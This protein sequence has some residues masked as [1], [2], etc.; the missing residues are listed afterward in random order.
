MNTPV[1]VRFAPSPTGYL[2]VGGVR[3]LLFNWLFAQKMGGKLILR[4]EDTDQARSTRQSEDMVIEDIVQLGLTGHEGPIDGG[5]HA[6]YRQS[7]RMDIYG[8]HAQQLLDQGK[9]YY[10]FCSPDVIAAKREVALKLGRIPHYD[11]TCA[12]QS[13]HDAEA[14]LAKGE[15]AGLRFRAPEGAVRLEDAVR[16]AIEFGAGSVGDFMIT[17]SPT[18]EERKRGGLNAQVGMPVYNFC[19]VIDDHLMG[20]TH[21]IRGED[22]LSNTAR[23]LMVYDGLGWTKPVFAHIAMVLGSDRQKLSKRNGD[24]SARDYLN[25]GYLPEA[26]L[27]F[28][29]LLGW[30]PPQGTKPVSGHP[31]VLNRDELIAGFGLEG[32]Q[33]APAVFDLQKLAWMNGFYIKQ[34]SRDERY[35]RSEPFLDE[36]LKKRWSVEELTEW[37][38]LFQGEATVLTDWNRLLTP[39]VHVGE[40]L[41]PELMAELKSALAAAL[42]GQDAQTLRKAL[43][44]ELAQANTASLKELPQRIAKATGL[45]GKALYMPMRL[46]LTGQAHGPELGRV[47]AVLGAQALN[48]RWA[49]TEPAW[50]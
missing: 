42:A 4:I 29:A 11:G 50:P 2:H 14:R 30:W 6:P 48:K 18:E 37:L 41:G 10:C 33:K 1:R 5:P 34:L 38:D 9:A 15:R 46:A 39:Y 12:R 45:K 8:K 28:L 17:R 43:S 7:E 20:I 35:R 19:C 22:H 44:A 16:G 23:Q 21:V 31:E 49:A 24:V 3:T 27:N 40:G 32:L 26:L 25:K 47:L 36:T 13:R